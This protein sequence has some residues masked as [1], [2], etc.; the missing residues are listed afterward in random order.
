MMQYDTCTMNMVV[1][2]LY[3]CALRGSGGGWG[4]NTCKVLIGCMGLV[5]FYQM[6]CTDPVTPPPTFGN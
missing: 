2:V 6:P 4:C 3:A 1:A 5:D